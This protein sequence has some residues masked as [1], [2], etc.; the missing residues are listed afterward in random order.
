MV[1]YLLCAILFLLPSYL[2]RFKV[3]G[4][5]T[6]FLEVLI[7]L[8][9]IILLFERIKEG[10]MGA[11]GW[12]KKIISELY[13]EKLFFFGAILIF[14]GIFLSSILA[15]NKLAAFGILKG[16]FIIPFMFFLALYGYIKEQT[17]EQREKKLRSLIIYLAM[18]GLIYLAAFALAPIFEATHNIRTD[19]ITFDGRLRIFFDSPN[20]LAMALAPVIFAFF[21]LFSSQKNIVKKMAY[22]NLMSVFI[23]LLLLTKSLGAILAVLGAFFFYFIIN[24]LTVSRIEFPTPSLRLLAGN[25]QRPA[26]N[27]LHFIFRIPNPI[28]RILYSKYFILNTLY[29]ILILSILTPLIF[30]FV[31]NQPSA[32]DRSSSASRIMIWQSARAI[33]ADNLFFGVGP[34]NFQDKYLDYQKNFPPYLDWAVPHPHN[35]FLTFLAS[36]GILGFI[37]FLLLIFW[38]INNLTLN[39]KYEILYTTYLIL[40]TLYFIF[41]SAVDTLYYKNDFSVVF[42]FLVALILLQKLANQSSIESI[43]S[44]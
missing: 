8:T 44:S 28:F 18:S 34:G 17:S 7:I 4:L 21:Y 12:A 35:T 33:L 40:Y 13:N 11:A 1:F 29:F 14:A 26:L 22:F 10:V 43:K 32:Q 3:F 31:Y 41:H 25:I 6:N 9:F 23:I 36:G 5:P 37:G 42:W 38:I 30:T 19:F 39:T 24:K 2:V 16:W 15:Q 27:I 20:Q